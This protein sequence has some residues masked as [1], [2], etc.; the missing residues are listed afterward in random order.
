MPRIGSNL[1]MAAVTIDTRH[2]LVVDEGLY[3]EPVIAWRCWMT[4]K[5]TERLR[6]WTKALSWTPNQEMEAKC[7]GPHKT[8]PFGGQVPPSHPSPS[9]HGCGMYGVKTLD[10][11]EQWAVQSTIG[12]I[13]VV[14]LW[15]R[16]IVCQDGYLAQFAYPAALVYPMAAVD[17]ELVDR[18][19]D[20]YGVPREWAA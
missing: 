15:G 3:V 8:L 18:L 10:Q 4:D 6:S 1:P 19:A 16:V 14:K 9:V 17:G 5:A 7:Y 13:G 20:V 11:A 2:N 12:V